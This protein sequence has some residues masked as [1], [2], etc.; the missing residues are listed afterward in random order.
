[1][2]NTF[3]DFDTEQQCEE[4]FEN[5]PGQLLEGALMVRVWLNIQSLTINVW[6]N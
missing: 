4:Y 6:N 3:S 5:N 1:M 2:N